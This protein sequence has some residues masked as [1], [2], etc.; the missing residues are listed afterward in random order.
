MIPRLVMF[1]AYVMGAILPA[2]QTYG[3]DA[4]VLKHASDA[5]ALVVSDTREQLG[6]AFCVRRQGLFVTTTDIAEAADEIYLV[7]ESVRGGERK[8]RATIFS[9]DAESGLVLLTTGHGNTPLELG[10]EAGLGDI[11]SV[12][13]IGYTIGRRGA[14]TEEYPTPDA[15]HCR[16]DSIRRGQ[17][18]TTD[19]DLDVALGPGK[20]GG[21]LIND[22]G[23]VV[24]IIRSTRSGAKVKSAIPVSTL[25]DLLRRP[26]LT[27]IP[28]KLQLSQIN[29]PVEFSVGMTN[30]FSSVTP[31]LELRLETSNGTQRRFPLPNYSNN[32]YRAD[33]VPVP[34]LIDVSIK[35]ADGSITGQVLDQKFE[36]GDRQEYLSNVRVLHFSDRA[37][38]VT[39]SSTRNGPIVGLE[40]VLVKLG[41]TE[42][43]MDLS[44]ATEV[45]LTPQAPRGD[46]LS[47]DYIIIA[48]IEDDEV[49]RLAGRLNFEG[50]PPAGKGASVAE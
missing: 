10:D 47:L 7:Q 33:V 13:A 35:S 2:L 37:L 32:H 42:F 46:V 15:T 31:R 44:K 21:P 30:Q 26:K 4:E 25:K 5:T 38:S 20:A 29:R 43:V 39:R 14:V 24:G 28:P 23:E 6:A 16:V 18:R 34:G 49:A 9:R 41:N 1:P 12:A 19:V 36:I 8:L 27:F 22:R 3:Q 40:S 11:S 45:L 50:L 17:A 48:S